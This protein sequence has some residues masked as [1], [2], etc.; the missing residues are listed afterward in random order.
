[1]F[2]FICFIIGVSFFIL[3]IIS[4]EAEGGIF[5]VFPFI[6]GSGL[7]PFLGFICIFISII[8]FSFGIMK[9]NIDYKS[10][11][12]FNG[13]SKLKRKELKGGGIVLTF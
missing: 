4:G 11:L 12:D 2:S 10:D 5:I 8:F 13:S 7:F 3:G 1:M 6:V 9:K